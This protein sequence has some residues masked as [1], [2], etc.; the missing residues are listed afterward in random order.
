[1]LI[2]SQPCCFLGDFRYYSLAIC[3][4]LLYI[5]GVESAFLFNKDNIF[6]SLA[7]YRRFAV[8]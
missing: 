3:E 7:V 8:L 5:V 6:Y 1:M 2:A 4:F